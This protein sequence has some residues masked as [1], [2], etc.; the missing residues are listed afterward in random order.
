MP[1]DTVFKPGQN[2]VQR[3]GEITRA[4]KRLQDAIGLGRVQV[5]IGANGAIA[6][7]GWQ[8]RDGITDAC[9]YRRLMSSGS[10]ELR[11]AIARAEAIAGVKVNE[12]VINGGAHSHDGGRTWGKH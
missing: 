3:A 2:I 10:S 1:C 4:L 6:F 12:R 8:D 7:A 9:A 5:K 11:R